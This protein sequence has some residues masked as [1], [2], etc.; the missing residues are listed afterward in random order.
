MKFIADTSSLLSLACSRH[1]KLIFSEHTFIITP[2]VREELGQ[3]SR[4]ED[5]LGLRAQELL[6]MK[7]TVLKPKTILSV[8]LESTEQEVFSLA[9]EQESV[10][11]TDDVHAARVGIEK[12]KVQARPSF[13]LLLLL[14]QKKKISREE[15]TE[16]LTAILGQRN[17]LRGALW[18]YAQALIERLHRD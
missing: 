3:F 15:L 14:Y 13:Y 2:L 18:N 7:L 10:V 4:Y 12:A 1:S 8:G 5:Y 6:Q 11:L 9:K 17:W 16:D